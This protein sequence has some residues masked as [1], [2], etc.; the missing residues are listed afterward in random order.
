MYNRLPLLDYMK[1][2]A[3]THWKR[4][5]QHTMHV[6]WYQEYIGLIPSVQICYGWSFASLSV[7]VCK[8]CLLKIK[9]FAFTH[10]R[11]LCCK[12]LV[13]EK[14]LTGLVTSLLHL[15]K[16]WYMS[17]WYVPRDYREVVYWKFLWKLYKS[18][19]FPRDELATSCL[20]IHTSCKRMKSSC[21]GL[22]STIIF[23]EFVI[24]I[25]VC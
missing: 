11:R 2:K 18:F 10:P 17:R 1:L 6:R 19:I 9:L 8:L 13:I 21:I 12:H 15:T 14:E 16:H 23:R 25:S 24:V 7:I 20:C 22:T 4:W 5:M 3:N